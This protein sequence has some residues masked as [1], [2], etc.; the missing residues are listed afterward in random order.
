MSAIKGSFQIDSENP[1]GRAQLIRTLEK[2]N[3]LIKGTKAATKTHI[4]NHVKQYRKWRSGNPTWKPTDFEIYCRRATDYIMTRGIANAQSQTDTSVPRVAWKHRV[5]RNE[6]REN[7]LLNDPVYKNTAGYEVQWSQQEG[8]NARRYLDMHERATKTKSYVNTWVNPACLHYKAYRDRQRSAVC[9]PINVPMGPIHSPKK[10]IPAK[11]SSTKRLKRKAGSK[12]SSRASTPSGNG[13]DGKPTI[14]RHSQALLD[15]IASRVLQSAMASASNDRVRSMLVK[16]MENPELN[17]LRS[18]GS[19]PDAANVP[20]KD[21][22]AMYKCDVITGFE[23][24]EELELSVQ[25]L[26][27]PSNEIPL[28][29]LWVISQ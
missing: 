11:G 5:H 20:K 6:Y 17:P 27:T 7:K 29:Y 26:P 9:S 25:V 18:Q 2:H 8:V 3:E 19:N 28:H 14:S 1:V 16:A 15:Q 21:F 4:G 10:S 12:A 24:R 13:K 23:A 22:K